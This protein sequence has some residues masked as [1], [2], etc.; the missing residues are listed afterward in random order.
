MASVFTMDQ[1]NKL[2]EAI[3]MGAFSITHKGKTI[4]YR[5]Q[6]EMFSLLNRME[7]DLNIRKSEGPLGGVRSFQPSINTE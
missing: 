4:T 7:M 3:S 1:Y 6:R 5:S 2:K